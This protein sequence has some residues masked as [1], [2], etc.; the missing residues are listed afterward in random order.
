MNLSSQQLAKLID[1]IFGETHAP[2]WSPKFGAFNAT[3]PTFFP[4]RKNPKRH[5]YSR[6]PLMRFGLMHFDVDPDVEAVCAFPFETTYWS[7]TQDDEA[8]K[9]VHVPDVAILMHGGDVVCIDFVP[10]MILF[11]RPWQ[12]VNEAQLRDHY[13]DEF[14]WAYAV[15]DE[16]RVYAQPMYSN[17]EL[18]W[19]YLPSKADPAY[20][21]LVRDAVMKSS[22]PATVATI[23]E[24]LTRKH[25]DIA[26]LGDEASSFVFTAIMQLVAEGRL[27]VD[28][29]LPITHD[30]VVM[31]ARGMSR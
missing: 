1:Y 15:H 26:K 22:R 4:T 31:S 18:L 14:G 29:S 20:L 27:F 3:L 12:A 2:A 19:R 5:V 11:E 6:L 25:P 13:F 8:V 10:V 28:M 23:I 7:T 21:S 9:R 16:R 17:V 30:T 24:L